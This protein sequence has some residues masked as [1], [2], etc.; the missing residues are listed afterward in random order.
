MCRP[1]KRVDWLTFQVSAWNA[2]FA[3]R[4]LPQDIQ[5]KLNDALVQA[6]DDEATRKRLLQIGCEIPN[7][8]DRTPQALQKFVESEVARW[9][10]VLKRRE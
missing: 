2:V 10:S 3:P 6:L 5:V 8:K 7:K 4:N 9:S 1:P